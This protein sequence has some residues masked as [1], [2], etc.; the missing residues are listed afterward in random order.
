MFRKK[1]LMFNLTLMKKIYDILALFQLNKI[2]NFGDRKTIMAVDFKLYHLLIDRILRYDSLSYIKRK[3]NIT[4]GSQTIENQILLKEIK[5]N[6][7][8][9]IKKYQKNSNI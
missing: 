6:F 4:K 8:K 1:G 5:S 2:W 7:S 3:L 9:I